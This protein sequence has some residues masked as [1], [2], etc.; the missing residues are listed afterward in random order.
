MNR[1]RLT[2]SKRATLEG[3]QSKV[4]QIEKGG[5]TPDHE[6]AQFDNFNEPRKFIPTSYPDAMS[7]EYGIGKYAVTTQ[8][9]VKLSGKKAVDYA[10]E[11]AL[12]GFRLTDPEATIVEDLLNMERSREADVTKNYRQKVERPAWDLEPGDTFTMDKEKF[13]VTGRDESGFMPKVTVK[14]G[15]T[16]TIEGDETLPIDRGSF[17]K[18]EGATP[19]SAKETSADFSLTPTEQKLKAIRSK[20]EQPK[21]DLGQVKGEDLRKPEPENKPVSMDELPIGKAANEA[22]DTAKQSAFDLIQEKKRGPIGEPK[23][24]V[25]SEEVGHYKTGITEI[26]SAE[27]AA[28]IAHVLALDPQE[29]FIGII[30][31]KNNKVLAVYQNSR[32]VKNASLVHQSE[33][34]GRVLNTEWAAHVWAAH[35]HPSGKYTP[36]Q[37]DIM[38]T[39]ALTNTLRGSPADL[40]GSLVI[41]KNDYYDIVSQSSGKI[42]TTEKT[43]TI[44]AI[45]R[46]F[47]KADPS[48]IR[49]I[50]AAPEYRIY[51]QK[52]IPDGGITLLDNLNQPVV[53]LPLS[54]FSKIRGDLQTDILKEAERANAGAMLVYMPNESR[55]TPGLL[56]Q[57]NNLSA[58]T[59]ATGIKLLDIVTSDFSYKDNGMMPS[60]SYEFYSF[61]GMAPKAVRESMESALHFLNSIGKHIPPGAKDMVERFFGLPN[62]SVENHPIRK[63][64]YDLNLKRSDDRV[65]AAM[66]V[67]A[68]DESAGYEGAK[69]LMERIGKMSK[70]E[71]AALDEI[72]YWGNIRKVEWNDRMLR[73][74]AGP[75]SK[76]TAKSITDAVIKAYG[77]NRQMLK[78]LQDT[79]INLM[80]RVALAPYVDEDWF[81]QL[82][83]H[84]DDLKQIPEAKDRKDYFKQKM[85]D[86]TIPPE[87]KGA[88][89]RVQ[90]MMEMIEEVKGIYDE[91][92]GYHPQVREQGDLIVRGYQ[93]V[94]GKAVEVWAQTAKTEAGA[95]KLQAEF[96]TTPEKFLRQHFE[97]DGSYF[98]KTSMTKL[99]TEETYM[100]I[101]REGAAVQIL[102][103]AIDRAASKG[104]ISKAD[105]D[106]I[107]EAAQEA[108]QEIMAARGA[109]R[110]F[111]KQ[112]PGNIEGYK[113]EQIPQL[114]VQQVHGIIGMLTKAEYA[115]KGVKEISKIP[116]DD[117]YGLRWV[118]SY[119]KDSLKNADAMDRIA[120]NARGLASLYYLGF[121]VSNW[122]V[123][124]TQH[125][126]TAI[127]E[128]GR[129]T[130]TAWALMDTARKDVV[131]G[132]LTEWDKQVLQ[133]AIDK[134]VDQAKLVRE[135]TGA[136][137]TNPFSGFNK[138]V[139]TSMK[140]FQY[141]ETNLNRKPAFLAAMRLFTGQKKPGG[142]Y[143]G[144]DKNG[145]PYSMGYEEAF[146]KAEEFVNAT[147]YVMGKEN[148]P[149]MVRKLGAAGRI[150]YTFMGFTH[151]YLAWMF[152]RARQGEVGVLA[153][154]LSWLW[155]FGGLAAIPGA[156]MIDS[157]LEKHF[158]I[159][160][161]LKIKH[162]IQDALK[163][164]TG[165]EDPMGTITDIVMHGLPTLA[166]INI[167]KKL[168]VN[169][170]FTGQGTVGDKIAGVWSSMGTK[171]GNAL[172]FAQEGDWYR[173]L[174]SAS[175]MAAANAMQAGRSAAQGMTTSS[176]HPVKIAGKSVKYTIPEALA[177]TAGVTPNRIAKYNELRSTEYNLSEY[178]QGKKD[179]L[180]KEFVKASPAERKAMAQ[181]WPEFNKKIR[182]AGVTGLV[183]PITDTTLESWVTEPMPPGKVRYERQYLQ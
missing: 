67:L 30:T 57:I 19:E 102:Q 71:K 149:E 123:N 83:G 74:S 112:A 169:I 8:D 31:D 182:D 5:I 113:T 32:G 173:S 80:E 39:K 73:R 114:M 68:P 177:K 135:V 137:E 133:D 166:G 89:K 147:H 16:H 134:G 129:H 111:I 42:P 181:K 110:H 2:P 3:I 26:K 60:A 163:S 56:S 98:A 154:S 28:H 128:M 146:K 167:S 99:P 168:S 115:I 44:P 21:L 161:K 66:H 50:T 131:T 118:Q 124:A 64:I 63:P 144:L 6:N 55:P 117:P 172:E 29:R 91:N 152:N 92:P 72:L 69:A 171:F 90:P 36:S 141:V 37:E 130:K 88:L 103:R 87:V 136:S 155:V 164:T 49:S 143:Y 53:N 107:Y 38:L 54:D 10:I 183:D 175:P 119:F 20:P 45:E 18:G 75:W 81:G 34:A 126:V 27:D 52:E 70:S 1:A 116:T 43:S 153:R 105:I 7:R 121:N 145:K 97:A 48:S 22:A 17:K 86:E 12:R 100:D 156:E 138:I 85:M 24:V 127:P 25:V 162:L 41:G 104:G 79:S 132:H 125:Y 59:N 35:N 33:F 47:Q 95:E 40:A 13:H 180:R 142:G 150:P 151:N 58:F 158:G 160:G 82:S 148:L 139:E 176:G 170:P 51:A 93:N 61:P 76:D 9:G 96:N 179:V 157:F 120:A 62:F 122:F 46:R 108:I 165:Y 11:R 78:K 14:D 65:E 15:I 101:G 109:R 84:V 23:N 106:P 178:W 4:G 140:G 77:Q 94:E 174:E 159:N